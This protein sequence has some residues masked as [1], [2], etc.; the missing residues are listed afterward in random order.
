VKGKVMQ[1]WIA[2]KPWSTHSMQGRGNENGFAYLERVLTY[3]NANG[4]KRQLASQVQ[5]WKLVIGITI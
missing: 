1:K 2:W 3:D 5:V 4:H